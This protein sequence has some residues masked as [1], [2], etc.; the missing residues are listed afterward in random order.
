MDE[1]RIYTTGELKALP[2]PK[3]LVE[4]VIEAGGLTFLSGSPGSG[5]TFVA[6]DWAG[7][8]LTGRDWHGKKVRQGT[9]LYVGS[10]G[11]FA[12]SSRVEAF[13]KHHH[14]ALNEGL[15][16]LQSIPLESPA[17]IGALAER[18]NRMHPGVSLIVIDTFARCFAGEENSAAEVGRAIRSIDVLRS[19]TKAAVLVVHHTAK[20][21]N[22]YRGS[23]ALEGAAEAMVSLVGTGKHRFTL[24]N[25]KQKNAAE[26]DDIALRFEVVPLGGGAEASCVVVAGSA[27]ATMSAMSAEKGVMLQVLVAATQAGTPLKNNEWN[28]R[29]NGRLGRNIAETTFRNWRRELEDAHF[30]KKTQDGR[31]VATAAA[32]ASV[33]PSVDGGSSANPSTAANTTPLSRGGGGDAEGG[34]G[35]G[36]P[37]PVEWDDSEWINGGF[38]RWMR[39]VVASIS[40]TAPSANVGGHS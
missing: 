29:V 4:G 33:A 35:V 27:S 21:G 17:D 7:H 40:E 13:E 12:L 28:G 26:F 22:G 23:S 2:K 14:V 11:G 3:W 9:V 6:L 10:E 19:K 36:A 15:F 1:V 24:K 8:V 18:L 34:V 30:I 25:D 20:K 32:C 16:V 37:T 5:K 31:W 39:E 38:D